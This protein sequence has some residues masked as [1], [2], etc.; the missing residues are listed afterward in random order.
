MCLSGAFAVGTCQAWRF[1]HIPYF[2]PDGLTL[3]RRTFAT[4]DQ[5]FVYRS[6]CLPASCF[7]CRFL[8]SDRGLSCASPVTAQVIYILGSTFTQ[9][10]AG[11]LRGRTFTLLRYC[12]DIYASR[13]I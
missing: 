6:G 9:P 3:L 13:S 1:V 12:F 4:H 7:Q 8:V 5:V 2:Q 11:V 10:D